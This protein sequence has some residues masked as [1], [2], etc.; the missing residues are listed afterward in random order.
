MTEQLEKIKGRRFFHAHETDR[1]AALDGVPLASFWQRYLG[2]FVDGILAVLVWFPIEF[3]W[4]R[5]LLHEQDI[6][7]IW[8]FHEKGN[9][10]VMVLYWGLFNYFGN[11]RSPGKWLARTQVLSLTGERMG[12]WQ[13]L[14]RALGYGAAFLEGGLGFFQFF[15]DR[16]RMCAQDRLAETIVVDL[17][18]NSQPAE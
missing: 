13:S 3:V 17:R 11:G 14:E 2:F 12:P 6:N 4:R 18:T 16:N 5:Y 1:A 9:I 8:N 15:W 10:V 7:M